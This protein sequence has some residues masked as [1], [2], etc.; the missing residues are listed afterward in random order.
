MAPKFNVRK[1]YSTADK[2]G[3]LRVLC[4]IIVP[5][6]KRI[7]G[8]NFFENKHCTAGRITETMNDCKFSCQNKYSALQSMNDC[9]SFCDKNRYTISRDEWLQIE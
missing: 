4:I 6:K 7:S 3:W 5:L 8:T 9:H 2:N 1:M